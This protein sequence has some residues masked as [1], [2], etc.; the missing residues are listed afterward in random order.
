MARKAGR[1]ADLRRYL[2]HVF[3]ATFVVAVLPV[4]VVGWLESRG[5]IASFWL[6]AALGAVLSIAASVMG[7]ALWRTR[8]GS[9]DVVFGD[10]MLWGWLRRLR[11][12][13]R[14]ARMTSLLG[15]DGEGWAAP[16]IS[17]TPDRQSEIL[18]RL[19]S[20]LEDRDPYTDG[21]TRRV[22]RHAYMTAA[23]MGLPAEEVERIRVA[24]SVHDVGKVDIPL[25]V[26]HKPGKLTDEEFALIKEHSVRG[27]EMVSA[28]G[29]HEITAMVRHHHERLDGRGY[30]DGLSGSAIPVG[31]RIIAVAD[32]FD[33]ITSTRSYRKASKHRQAIEILKKE[34][35]TQLDPDAVKAF[36]AYYSGRNVFEWW[37]FLTTLPQRFLASIGSW[38]PRIGAA[39]LLKGAA[40]VGAAAVVTGSSLGQWAPVARD[41]SASP[42]MTMDPQEVSG[43]QQ[44]VGEV[45]APDGSEAT[46]T[47]SERHASVPTTDSL[48][49]A[50]QPPT[51]PSDEE[52]VGDGTEGA[53]DGTVGDGS[54]GGGGDNGDS[55]GTVDDTVDT[56]DGVVDDTVD[57][58]DDTVDTV[59]DTVEDTA[60]TVDDTADTVED[61]VDGV[62]DTVGD[63]AEGAGETLDDLLP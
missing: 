61:T 25:E 2:P 8:L 50:T 16:D 60:E 12:E 54:S 38:F 37:A 29:S 33:A 5:W 42:S 9:R 35:G 7:S 19:A 1:G 45:E 44:V 27:A 56:V 21:H 13:R 63:V 30:P 55:G 40:A 47:S 46:T 3:V 14:L 28:I 62:V 26:L 49:P 52:P 48:P 34:A 58:V 32:T 57:T 43:V 17:I 59:D 31:A 39:S 11:T 53:P 18:R 6:A 4:L 15:L 20:A 22:T 10:L 41:R 36:L 51:S 23:S 24:A